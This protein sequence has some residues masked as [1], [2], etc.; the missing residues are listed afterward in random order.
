MIR[1]EPELRNAAEAGDSEAMAELARQLSAAGREAEATYWK[2]RLEEA[3]WAAGAV[4]I[5]GRRYPPLVLL[6]AVLVGVLGLLATALVVLMYVFAGQTHDELL[7]PVL[8]MLS[9][10]PGAAAVALLTAAVG[11]L[12]GSAAAARRAQTVTS[13]A[14]GLAVV[15]ALWLVGG[16][17]TYGGT[18]TALFQAVL[19]GAAIVA[20]LFGLAALLGRCVPRLGR[21]RRETDR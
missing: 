9:L 11:M 2:G 3:A 14:G 21:T 7:V 8:I 10:V 19:L 4:P 16:A 5:G 15:G 17:L 1:D 20:P 6:A 18:G 12:R 13:S